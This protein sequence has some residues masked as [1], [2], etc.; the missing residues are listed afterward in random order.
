LLENLFSGGTGIGNQIQQHYSKF[1]N[2]NQRNPA[3]KTKKVIFY[4]ENLDQMRETV[5]FNKFQETREDR[6]F[7]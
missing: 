4:L 5:A 1:A 7:L 6:Q 3:R 2:S